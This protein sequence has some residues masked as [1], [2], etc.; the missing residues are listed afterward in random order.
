MQ[1]KPLGNTTQRV[2]PYYQAIFSSHIFVG[3]IM[4]VSSV[5]F[6]AAFAGM[7]FALMKVHRLYRGAGFTMD[8]A[9]KEFTDGVMADRNVQ[10]ATN[11]AARAAASMAVN[12]AVGRY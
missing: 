2:F 11:Q 5:A 9:R 1:S 3:L 4:L 6:S 12:D 7:V 8:K 10:Q